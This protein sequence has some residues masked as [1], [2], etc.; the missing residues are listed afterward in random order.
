[1]D[2]PRFGQ[3]RQEEWGSLQA[4]HLLSVMTYAGRNCWAP[5]MGKKAK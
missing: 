2:Y 1:M 5:F 4:E 3:L